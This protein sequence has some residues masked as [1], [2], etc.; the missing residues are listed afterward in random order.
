MITAE[1]FAEVNDAYRGT[2]DGVPTVGTTDHDYW[3]RIANRKINEWARD[4][5]NIWES[6][7]DIKTV[8]VGDPLVDVVIVAGTQDYTLNNIPIAL[9]DKIIVTDTD[10]N[11]HTYQIIKAK[12]RDRFTEAVYIVGATLTFVD[13]INTG[14]TIVGGT[15]K[16]PGYWMP[17]T[18]TTGAIVIDDPYWLVYAVAADLAS[19]DL[20]YSAKAGNLQAQANNLYMAMASANRRGTN[21]NPRK[22]PT[23]IERITGV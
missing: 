22:T 19:N 5:K 7:W 4:T 9:S 20:T 21:N 18:L 16:I 1:L 3:L 23:N 8:Q 2:D 15:I 10:G 6:L 17:T 13:D 12:E 14:D 11:D